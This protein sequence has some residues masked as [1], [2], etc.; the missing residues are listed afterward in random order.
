MHSMRKKNKRK[1]KIEDGRPERGRENESERQTK[2]TRSTRG[3]MVRDTEANRQEDSVV[4]IFV[5][6]HLLVV[7]FLPASWGY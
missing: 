4:F 1:K 6:S 2:A 3:H 7:K 5:F